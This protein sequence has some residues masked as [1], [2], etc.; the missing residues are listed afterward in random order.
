MPTT[1]TKK[2][3]LI[4]EDEVSLRNA[5]CIKFNREGFSV[6]DAKDGE[7]GLEIALAKTPDIILLDMVMPKLDG[8]AMLKK[9]RATN[10]WGKNVPVILLTNLGADDEHRNKTIL[11]DENVEYLVKSDWAIGDLVE[12]VRE[13]VNK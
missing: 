11:N 13:V 4:V 6:I 9:L 7:A 5:L 8:M 1:I 12:K 10:D 2:L 3:L